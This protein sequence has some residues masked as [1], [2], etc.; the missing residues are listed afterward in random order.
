[1][2]LVPVGFVKADVRLAS[3]SR[4]GK[5]CGNAI[6]PGKFIGTNHDIRLRAFARGVYEISIQRPSIY[7]SATPCR[8]AIKINADGHNDWRRADWQPSRHGQLDG[9]RLHRQ[10]DDKQCQKHSITSMSG[11]VFI[12]T[13]RS[14]VLD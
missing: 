4:V 8:S 12:S 10:S 5:H 2:T 1:M 6:V 3:A 7:F 13:T 11:V 9:V 14:P